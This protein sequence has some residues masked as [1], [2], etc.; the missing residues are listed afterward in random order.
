MLQSINAEWFAQQWQFPQIKMIDHLDVSVTSLYC[1]LQFGGRANPSHIRWK[2][3]FNAAISWRWRRW[4]SRGIGRCST[5]CAVIVA[6]EFVIPRCVGSQ[7][8]P[9]CCLKLVLQAASRFFS[10]QGLSQDMERSCKHG[11]PAKLGKQQLE[12]VSVRL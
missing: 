3:G 12:N 11:M 1:I 7:N 4:W 2:G 8:S 10:A 5:W 6:C 9:A